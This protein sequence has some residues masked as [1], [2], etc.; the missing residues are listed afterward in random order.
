MKILIISSNLIGDTIL[1]TSII[2]NLHSKYPEGKFT[3]IIGPSAAQLYINFPAKEK[4]IIVKKKNF[5]LHWI[6]M[7][8]SVFKTKWDIIVDFR[9]SL[10]SY[11]LK[12][13]KKYIFKKKKN[14]NHIDQLQN[15]F[16]FK[17]TSLSISTNKDEEIN[18]SNAISDIYK[19][20][21]LFPGGNWKPKIWPTNY[22]NKLIFLLNNKFTNLKFIV[23]GSIIE[24][25]LYLEDIM[26]G[27]P[28]NDFINLMGKSLTET[29]AYMTK[30]NLFIG[31]DSG[32]MHL[33]VA[34]NLKTI[35]L[36]G[37][38][39]DKIYG[40]YSSNSF[41]IRTKKNYEDFNR[42]KMDIT[43]SY[44]QTITPEIVLNFI[45]KNKLL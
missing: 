36:F 33:S 13:K 38:T 17:D 37:P 18:A 27:L 25:N 23:V 6:D 41:V 15:F 20:V 35:A 24:K 7:Y 45:I 42:E 30:S 10:I 31:N 40:H 9:S 2:N 21:V 3:F 5:N 19:Y 8:I 43:K 12:N 14:L 44:M 22:F 28:T 34:S 4:I 32:L 26:K 11:F 29:S 16:Q 1:S 39:N